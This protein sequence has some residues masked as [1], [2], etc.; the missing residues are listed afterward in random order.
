VNVRGPH[1][2]PF[3]RKTESSTVARKTSINQHHAEK[4][5]S[6]M[7]K[8]VVA[9]CMVACV[10]AVGG[11]ADAHSI[12]RAK[13]VKDADLVCSYEN[14]RLVQYKGGLP[15]ITNPAKAT[16]AQLHAYGKYLAYSDHLLQDLVKREFAL[17]TP[18]EPAAKTSW[19]RWHTLY[20]TILLPAY[21]AAVKAADAGDV[22]GVLTA[23]AAPQKY[24]GE[25]H[26]LAKVLGFKVC[27]WAD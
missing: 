26:K 6:K 24:S 3:L 7:M 21:T 14:G 18:T 4:V 23:F 2:V 19:T 5:G 20:T 10:L 15:R 22:K 16:R 1:R 12:P 9:G 8:R 13:L 25:A 27:S 17:G 11:T